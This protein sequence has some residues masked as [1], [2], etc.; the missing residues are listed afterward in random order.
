MQ[1]LA[2]QSDRNQEHEIGFN[3]YADV[4]L[5]LG[6]VLEVGCG[7]FT[8]LITILNNR[9]AKSITLLD[10]LLNSYLSLPNCTYKDKRLLGYDCGHPIRVK[11]NVFSEWESGFNALYNVI[12]DFKDPLNQMHYFI[13]TKI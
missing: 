6:N 9:A 12:P 4:P 8:Q 2:A 13:G 3:Y 11:M 5:N 10:P 7:P 1:N